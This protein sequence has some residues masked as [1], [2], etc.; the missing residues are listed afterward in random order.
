MDL[1]EAAI[2]QK[3]PEAIRHPWEQARLEVVYQI[4]QDF[5]PQI[6]AQTGT[7]LD[8]GCGD[9]FFVES[10]SERMPASRFLAVDISFEETMLQHLRKKF[11]NRSIDIYASLPD[12]LDKGNYPH[13]DIVLLLDVIE[14]IQDDISFM[15]WLSSFPQMS[16]GT[17]FIIS[18]PAFQQLFCSHDYFLEHYRRYTN[19]SLK[20]HMH[21]AGLEI[22][23]EGYFFSSLLIPRGVRVLIEKLN[24]RPRQAQGIGAWQGGNTQTLLLKN[25]LITDFKMTRFLHRMGLKLP[26]LSNYAICRKIV[27]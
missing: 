21:E 7:V 4:L 25:A 18:V 22:I 23:K 24:P 20:R 5:L 11:E 9:T 19:A 1:K 13:I 12:A 15:R 16:S 3:Q 10:L 27:S 8:M 26:G 2:H 14:H 17:L 6:E